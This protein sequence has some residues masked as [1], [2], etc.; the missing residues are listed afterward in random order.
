M[1]MTDETAPLTDSKTS[2]NNKPEDTLP[3]P[4]DDQDALASPAKEAPE[5]S[6]KT[7]QVDLEEVV[8][9]AKEEEAPPHVENPRDQLAKAFQDRRR[10]ENSEEDPTSQDGDQDGDNTVTAKAEAGDEDSQNESNDESGDDDS[11]LEAGKA[12]SEPA[13]DDAHPQHIKVKIRGKD[14]EM[15]PEA[16]SAIVEGAFDAQQKTPDTSEVKLPAQ[17]D[18]GGDETG[19]AD[20]NEDPERK[21]N[22]PINADK[23][24]SIV[25]RIQVGDSDDG[26]AALQE[27]IEI[28]GHDNGAV[29]REDAQQ[30]VKDA[31]FETN[32]KDEVDIAVN[33]FATKFD[34]ITKDDLMMRLSLDIVREELVKDVKSALPSL[35]DEDIK[36]FVSS[37]EGARELHKNFKKQGYK[38]RTV[39]EVLDNVGQTVVKKFN[40]RQS[41]DK[42]S[43]QSKS[44]S[45][46]RVSPSSRP[47]DPASLQ[48]RIDRK[49]ATPQQPRP[50]GVRGQVSEAPRPKTTKEK[51]LE[52]KNARPSSFSNA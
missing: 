10:G 29:S 2:S 51:I 28:N 1:V 14:V 24:K 31:I 47:R 3:E 43:V 11:V 34:V 30:M 6:S 13:R 23:L 26:V 17:D 20:E 4:V 18:L 21:A 9:A 49:R 5:Q 25:E 22:A 44:S 50:A 19:D 42:P 16:L 38:L 27:L 39:S 35:T 8:D 52:M 33:N 36:P 37:L 41:T 46:D 15:S 32:F 45:Q 40:L 48:R 7:G 12:K